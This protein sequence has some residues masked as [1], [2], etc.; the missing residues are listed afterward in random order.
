M[1][2]TAWFIS[3]TNRGLGLE[4]VKQLSG[5]PNTIVF[6]GVRDLASAN[7][8]QELAASSKNIHIVK[9]DS[10]SVADAQAAAKKVEEI[11]GGLD[12]VI[13]NAGNFTALWTCSRGTY[14]GDSSTL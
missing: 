8:L 12:V 3:G 9:L 13:A 1:S 6:A 4:L 5:C 7:A 11:A 10:G 14:T 2:S